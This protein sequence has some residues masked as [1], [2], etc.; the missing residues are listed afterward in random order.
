[1]E[2]CLNSR[3]QSFEWN[4]QN[5]TQITL[6]GQP[7]M[8]LAVGDCLGANGSP[9]IITSCNSNVCPGNGNQLWDW[10]IEST[11]TTSLTGNCLDIDGSIGPGECTALLSS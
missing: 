3:N 2:P 9:L 8:C 6:K 10:D 5:N 7:D 1:M 4:Q 11:I